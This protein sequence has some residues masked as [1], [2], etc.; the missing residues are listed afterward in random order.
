MRASRTPAKQSAG[1]PS[2][3]TNEVHRGG[4]P[5][6]DRDPAF[7]DGVE[8][9][10]RVEPLDEH[11]TGT[12]R[13]RRPDHH[14]QT[15][16]VEDRQ[17]AVDD[18]RRPHRLTGRPGLL[19]VRQQVAVA[20]HG[21]PR[22]TGGPAREDQHGQLVVGDVDGGARVGLQQRLD[23]HRSLEREGGRRDD[24]LHRRHRGR[25]DRTPHRESGLL[26]DD[27]PGVH[28][29]QFTLEFGR[30]AGRV[31]RH[32]DGAETDRGEVRHHEV[33]TVAA[34]QGDGVAAGHAECRQATAHRRHLIAQGAV[35][36]R[37][38][39]ADQCHGLRVVSL[40]DVGQVHVSHTPGGR[41][42]SPA[43]HG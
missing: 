18:V 21:G 38:T 10:G 25:V 3:C 39:T 33:P 9:R 4:A 20:E 36:R 27:G 23:R 32:G 37:P 7:A 11:H 15:E 22:R 34:E 29:G 13:Q 40:D 16:D 1:R 5:R 8:H 41:L 26:D 31:Q 14:V 43:S 17:H 28:H 12:R 30:R 2:S 35:R 6:H 42:Y 24:V 19:D